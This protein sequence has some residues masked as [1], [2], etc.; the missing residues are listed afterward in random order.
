LMNVR[1]DGF[2]AA[3][4]RTPN[5]A[6]VTLSLRERPRELFRRAAKKE[7]LVARPSGLQ[8]GVYGDDGGS[9]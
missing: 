8:T 7:R 2:A 9:Y 1:S 5:R 6:G 4:G 3:N